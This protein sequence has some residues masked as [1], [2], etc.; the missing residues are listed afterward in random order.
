[1]SY[2]KLTDDEL[3]EH[4]DLLRLR[5][6]EKATPEEVKRS[7]ELLRRYFEDERRELKQIEQERRDV[8]H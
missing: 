3:A 5:M 8:Q 2:A 6:N 7:N 1:M 4:V